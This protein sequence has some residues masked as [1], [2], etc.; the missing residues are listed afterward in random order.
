MN[1]R[2]RK[3]TINVVNFINFR[4]YIQQISQIINNIV[5][6]ELEKHLL[7]KSHQLFHYR[8]TLQKKSRREHDL[9]HYQNSKT[10]KKN[11]QR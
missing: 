1:H 9:I 2:L 11:F 5:E 3:K 6:N 7:Q 8:M 4:R 10:Q